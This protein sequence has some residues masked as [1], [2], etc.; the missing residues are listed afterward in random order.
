VSVPTTAVSA[1]R[2][3]DRIRACLSQRH[4]VEQLTALIIVAIVQMLLDM[5]NYQALG[6]ISIMGW[7]L[8]DII[9]ILLFAEEGGLAQ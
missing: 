6:Y 2:P 7:V 1:P 3:R 8:R 4:R 9:I 5:H